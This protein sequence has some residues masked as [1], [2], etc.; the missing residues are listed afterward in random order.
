[1]HVHNEKNERKA[2]IKVMKRRKANTGVEGT[3]NW[4]K[5]AKGMISDAEKKQV[6]RESTHFHS[7]DGYSTSDTIRRAS[8]L[9]HFYVS[10]NRE[11]FF[12]LDGEIMHML[13]KK[14]GNDRGFSSNDVFEYSRGVIT[15]LR[16]FLSRHKKNES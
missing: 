9:T 8:K 16:K 12:R 11:M 5:R 3:V 10:R 7:A 15:I 14:N 13:A 2:G 6:K 4:I 1:M